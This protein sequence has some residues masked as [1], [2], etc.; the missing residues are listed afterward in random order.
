MVGDDA[1]SVSQTQNHR[2][3]QAQS[4]A[5]SKT[6]RK[7]DIFVSGWLD[8]RYLTAITACKAAPHPAK[9]LT[10]EKSPQPPLLPPRTWS[11]YV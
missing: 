1:D 9:R 2:V 7:V 11:A 3:A 10:D 6:L 8:A 4:D 5:E